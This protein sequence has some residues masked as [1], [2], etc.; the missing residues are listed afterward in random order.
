MLSRSEASRSRKGGDAAM[1]PGPDN[2]GP[3]RCFAAAQHD[4]NENWPVQ[5]GG[6]PNE[7]VKAHQTGPR[8]RVTD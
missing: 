2:V 5:S 6:V 8:R 3:A 4:G 1:R 7:P